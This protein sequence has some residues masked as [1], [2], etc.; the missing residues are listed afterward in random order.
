[1]RVILHFSF[2]LLFLIIISSDL[3]A[4][5][6]GRRR[7]VVASNSVTHGVEISQSKSLPDSLLLDSVV[8]R[9]FKAVKCNFSVPAQISVDTAVGEIVEEISIEEVVMEEEEIT[10]GG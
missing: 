7:A 5:R 3:D 1:M 6:A 2:T 4:Q 9:P 10:C 8:T